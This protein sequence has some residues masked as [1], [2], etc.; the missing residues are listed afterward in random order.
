MAG[1]GGSREAIADIAPRWRRCS[2][3]LPPAPQ[4]GGIEGLVTTAPPRL[5]SRGKST[6][7]FLSP[8]ALV[9]RRPRTR[10]TPPRTP[11]RRRRCRCRRRGRRPPPGAIGAHAS[12]PTRPSSRSATGGVGPGVVVERADA[13]VRRRVPP[14]TPPGRPPAAVHPAVG[15]APRRRPNPPPAVQTDTPDHP[16]LLSCRRR[17]RRRPS[18]RPPVTAPIRVALPI[19]A[20]FTVAGAARDGARRRAEQLAHAE[21]RGERQLGAGDVAEARRRAR[22]AR[23]RSA[24]RRC[25]AAPLAAR[26]ARRRAPAAEHAAE[27][28]PPPVPAA[29]LAAA[30]RRR[31]PPAACLFARRDLPARDSISGNSPCIPFLAVSLQFSESSPPFLA[32]ESNAINVDAKDPGPQWT[33]CSSSRWLLWS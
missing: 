11:P 19:A 17:R 1:G 28:P 22:S 6:R 31:R 3:G 14:S 23:R 5:F 15:P 10:A 25:R 12:G 8:A 2:R 24:P 13:A 33:T 26:R 27:R 4:P 16:P 29:A 32:R 9:S 30:T 21:E 7:S 20:P 18:R